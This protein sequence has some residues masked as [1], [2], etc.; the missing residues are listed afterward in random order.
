MPGKPLRRRSASMKQLTKDEVED[1]EQP[2]LTVSTEYSIDSTSPPITSSD[3]EKD[4]S[5]VP[6]TETSS[7][8]NEATD[9]KGV[10]DLSPS[11]QISPTAV[12][13]PGGSTSLA[14]K[15]G[16]THKVK[17]SRRASFQLSNTVNNL[18]KESGV[19]HLIGIVNQDKSGEKKKGMREQINDLKEE[20]EKKGR[21]QIQCGLYMCVLYLQKLNVAFFFN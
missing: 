12:V 20:I 7:E 14:K 18:A 1:L 2:G 17:S 15:R 8:S 13:R 3:S 16:S 9:H 4:M 6:T 19:D 10:Q 5:F 11:G 21:Q